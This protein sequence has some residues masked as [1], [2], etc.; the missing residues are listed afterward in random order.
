MTSCSTS[1]VNAVSAL[2]RPRRLVCLIAL[3]LAACGWWAGQASAS[4]YWGSFSSTG[5]VGRANLDGSGANPGFVAG[6][7]SPALVA[8]DGQHIYWANLNGTTIG[9]ANL[10][11]TGANQSFI[12][13]ANT[14]Q[15]IAVDGQHIYWVAGSAVG[16]ANLD[17]TGANASFIT[18]ASNPAGVAVD[19]QHVYWANSGGGATNTIGRANLDGTGANQSFI[20]GPNFPVGVAVDG[21]HVYWANS[22]GTTIGRANLD[23]T[24]A[25]E[26]FISGASAP[27]GV[28][29]DGQ[30]LYW[31]NS[32]ATTIG[33]ANLDGSAANQ[34]FISGLN[35]P[36][37]VAVD[38]GPAGTAT[39][40]ASRLTFDTQPLDTYSSPQA[41]TLTNTGHGDLNIGRVQ[42]TGGNADDFLISYDSCSNNVML[43]GAT[44][45]IDIR[46]GPSEAAP[47]AGTLTV[48]SDDP[49]S[50]L[51]IALS[52]TGGQLPQGAA[53]APGAA[54]PPGPVGPKGPAG[55]SGP[56]GPTGA[57]GPAGPAGQ[58]ELVT[59]ESVTV[60]GRRDRADR[61]ERRCQAHLIAGPVNFTTTEWL[62]AT[63]I[64]RGVVY[65]AV[66]HS[67]DGR[68]LVLY[69]RRRLVPGRYTL[70]L[71]AGHRHI[72]TR[73]ITLR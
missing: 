39:S 3:A 15:G 4:V 53:G 10:D 2:A 42:A 32:G 12:G 71:T 55:Q 36:A 14:P 50:P 52:G 69:V 21:Q 18:G 58:I 6:G 46:F 20:T 27:F 37:G 17:G 59:C 49:T 43:V 33:R 31:A 57:R 24:S 28:A 63:L 66:V 72:T 67:H 34:S 47:R 70:T 22:G 23:G 61:R 5:E 62:R 41:L 8:I 56:S 45:T 30:H 11:G 60:H 26:S 1:A 7:N 38:S 35:V 73:A 29:V 54:G 51:L 19:G 40:N 68:R 9:R 44:C 13:L 64:R 65:G 25:S 48:P 16:R